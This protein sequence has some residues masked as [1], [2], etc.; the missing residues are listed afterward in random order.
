MDSS[1]AELPPSS[2]SQDSEASLT[3]GQGTPRGTDDDMEES[4]TAQRSE[5]DSYTLVTSRKLPKPSE[6]PPKAPQVGPTVRFVPANYTDSLTKLSTM[7]VSSELE[8]HC[9]ESIQ[10]IRPNNRLNLITVDTRNAQA[11]QSHLKLTSLCGLTVK[12]YEPRPRDGAVGVIKCVGDDVDDAL[13]KAG[14]TSEIPVVHARGLGKSQVVRSLFNGPKMSKYVLFSRVRYQVWEFEERPLQCANCGR[15]CH[16]TVICTKNQ[17]DSRCGGSHSRASCDASPLCVNCSNEHDALVASCPKQVEQRELAKNR[18]VH[19]NDQSGHKYTPEVGQ[20]LQ[21]L[22]PLQRPKQAGKETAIQHPA[23]QAMTP[24]L[25]L[26]SFAWLSKSRAAQARG[27]VTSHGAQPPPPHA[28][29]AGLRIPEERTGAAACPAV[30][31]RCAVAKSDAAP[32]PLDSVFEIYANAA[33]KNGTFGNLLPSF[34]AA[35]TSPKTSPD[36]FRTDAHLSKAAQNVS[37]RVRD[38][39]GTCVCVRVERP[40]LTA[41]NLG[42]DSFLTTSRR[43][44]LQSTWLSHLLPWRRER[45]KTDPYIRRGPGSSRTCGLSPASNNWLAAVG[46][47]PCDIVLHLRVSVWTLLWDSPGFRLWVINFEL[48]GIL[49]V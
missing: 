38:V 44:Q 46:I 6:S 49:S 19:N 41:E 18:R 39:N 12:S 36:V 9:P 34:N 22:R 15:F 48:L 5:L 26:S 21:P 11:T 24:S 42:Y 37:Q 31:L 23:A 14:L 2:L 20:P 1:A 43:T 33:V 10:V 29:L 7:R 13:L 35:E 3:P 32:E 30:R 27:A 4:A 17:M 8:N 40:G 47:G 25:E 16:K 28:A 45:E